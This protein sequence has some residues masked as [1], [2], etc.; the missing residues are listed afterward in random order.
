MQAVQLSGGALLSHRA[1]LHANAEEVTT[2]YAA[3]KVTTLQGAHS[4]ATVNGSGCQRAHT[5]L[6]N[7]HVREWHRMPLRLSVANPTGMSGARATPD[8]H[9]SA[10]ALAQSTHAPENLG[11]WPQPLHTHAFC[12]L[13][14]AEIGT[15]NV[16]ANLN[17][18]CH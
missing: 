10:H 3:E 1:R 18:F 4:G 6:E 16:G 7:V 12:V 2:M 8:L 11:P 5:R 17:T 15:L 9:A 14:L 13:C